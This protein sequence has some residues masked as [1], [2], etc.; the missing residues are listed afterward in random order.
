[1]KY[2]R[3]VNNIVVE[4]FI[5]LDGFDIL[6]CFTAEIAEQFEVISD[7]VNPQWIKDATG[8]FSSPVIIEDSAQ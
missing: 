7:E 2:G 5:P 3:I 6:E 8:K 1:M 4:T